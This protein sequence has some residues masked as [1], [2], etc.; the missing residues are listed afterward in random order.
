M[1][2]RNN[3]QSAIPQLEQEIKALKKTGTHN[4]EAEIKKLEADIQALR[5]LA[6]KHGGSLPAD[7]IDYVVDEGTDSNWNYIKWKNGRCELWRQYT[8][9]FAMTT[10]TGGWYAS[11]ADRTLTLPFEVMDAVVTGCGLDAPYLIKGSVE[12]ATLTWRPYRL[13]SSASTERKFQLTIVGR[14]K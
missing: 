4:A 13:Q 3:P 9:T 14:W 7:L 2:D 10:S 12:G 5:K 6:K 1:L 8:A 11:S